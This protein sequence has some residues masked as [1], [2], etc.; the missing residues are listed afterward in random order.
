MNTTA[1]LV[2]GV[3][4]GLLVA[5]GG[6]WLWGASGERA[7]ARS[8]DAAELRSDL[9]EG[10]GRLLEARVDLY[11]VNFG[12]ASRHLE[13]ARTALRRAAARLKNLG[14]GDDAGRV[15][16]TL[17]KIDES[18]QMAGKLDQGSNSRVAEA[19]AAVDDVL[20]PAQPR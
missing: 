20:W 13:D 18:Q 17:K 1:K 8:L 11:N 10:R 5:A 14:R 4:I 15:D 9:V 2:L 6:G 3:L 19:V 16:A 12:D 7:T